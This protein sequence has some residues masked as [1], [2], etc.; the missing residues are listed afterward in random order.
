MRR[1]P[2]RRSGA[3]KIQA[4]L[5]LD[6]IDIHSVEVGENDWGA[7][8]VADKMRRNPMALK[9]ALLDVILSPFE[10]VQ[11]KREGSRAGDFLKRR[12][13]FVIRIRQANGQPFCSIEPT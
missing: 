7:E 11:R 8:D 5:G 13:S 3:I 1:N 2:H 6:G 10:F 12:G 9:D 4:F